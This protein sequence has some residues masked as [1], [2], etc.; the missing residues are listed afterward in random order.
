METEAMINRGRF[1]Q[2]NE[3]TEIDPGP[4]RAVLEAASPVCGLGQPT[5]GPERARV[6][7]D[8]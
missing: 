3:T 6:T 2:R 1:L 4:A 8:V 5:E 7:E